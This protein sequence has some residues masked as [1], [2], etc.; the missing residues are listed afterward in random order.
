MKTL[1]FDDG[2]TLFKFFFVSWLRGPKIIPKS[3][4]NRIEE[5]LGHQGPG[6]PQV[7]AK[8]G[9]GSPWGQLED[10]KRELEACLEPFA[11]PK[12]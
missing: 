11:L 12:G 3:F 1:I 5:L 6:W 4:Q 10:Q 8:N 2:A 7:L 9:L